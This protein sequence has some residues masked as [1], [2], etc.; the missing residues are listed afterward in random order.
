MFGAVTGVDLR[1]CGR[2]LGAGPGVCGKA[3]VSQRRALKPHP[4]LW[5]GAQTSAPRGHIRASPPALLS[6]LWF[7][8]QP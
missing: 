2:L 3:P 7:A 5:A 4:D 8:P 1:A 6:A